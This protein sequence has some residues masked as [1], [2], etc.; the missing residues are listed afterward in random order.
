MELPAGWVWPGGQVTHT[1]GNIIVTVVFQ[2]CPSGVTE[3]ESGVL[4][5]LQWYHSVCYSVGI[6]VA[7][8]MGVVTHTYGNII[9]KLSAIISIISQY[10][11]KQEFS[12]N[13]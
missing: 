7:S 12:K 3:F 13:C 5:V 1:Y 9:V 8:G 10:G 4:L 6:R 11:S 2:R